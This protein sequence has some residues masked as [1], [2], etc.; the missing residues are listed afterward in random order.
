MRVS[1]YA[2]AWLMGAAVA[3]APACSD[4]AAAPDFNVHYEP[5]TAGTQVGGFNLAI[6]ADLQ[7]SG[8]S[9]FNGIVY[10]QPL[11]EADVAFARDGQCT[12]MDPA[13]LNWCETA[14]LPRGKCAAGFSHSAGIVRLD[15]LVT[16][17]VIEP[18][19]GGFMGYEGGVQD[20]TFPPAAPGMPIKL[21]TSGGDYHPFTLTARGIS[22]L[23]PS[24][25]TVTL[26]PG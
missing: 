4:P 17:W 9:R 26:D 22:P 19:Q 24:L 2:G 20:G 3:G 8:S 11:V 13:D 7:A 21:S 18:F 15:G 6:D 23:I 10:D 5:C 12:L 1:A 14:D 25:D 16:P